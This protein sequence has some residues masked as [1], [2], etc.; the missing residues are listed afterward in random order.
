[1]RRFPFAILLAAAAVS[2]V[3]AQQPPSG[4]GTPGSPGAV[5]SDHKI[6]SS[7]RGFIDDAA[8][9]GHFEIETSKLALKKSGSAEVKQFAQRMID[10]HTKVGQELGQLASKKGVEAP[11]EPSLMQKGKLKT[12]DLRDDGFDKAYADDAV[13]AH[14]S[15]VELF[16]K[17]SKDAK[18]ADVKAFA[19]KN[20]PALQE[21]L[22]MAQQLQ[23]TT[24]A[25]KQ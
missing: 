13:S 7:D 17:A 4:P 11:T 15:A 5:N 2:P 21:H 14:E 9:A 8:K 23:K 10:D 3:L 20:L 19:A 12:L 6:D 16:E 1:M 25:A 22:K 18:D 24:E